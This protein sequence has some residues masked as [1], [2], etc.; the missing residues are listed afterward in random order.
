MDSR[1]LPQ[2]SNPGPPPLRVATG[3]PGQ[4]LDPRV[5]DSTSQALSTRPEFR[6]RR[7]K[8]LTQYKWNVLRPSPF[9]LLFFSHVRCSLKEGELWYWAQF[10]LQSLFPQL[11]K[12]ISNL[13]QLLQKGRLLAII[14]STCHSAWYLVCTQQMLSQIELPSISASSQ[15]LITKVYW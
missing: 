1:S 5:F 8:Q 13:S 12:S 7:D 3:Y 4:S 2:G 11:R 9:V 10:F 14:A 6:R 15:L